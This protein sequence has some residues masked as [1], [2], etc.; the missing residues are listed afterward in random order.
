MKIESKSGQDARG[1]L[2]QW[3]EREMKER[4]KER[5]KERI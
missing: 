1:G 3:G 5:K 4:K 2:G